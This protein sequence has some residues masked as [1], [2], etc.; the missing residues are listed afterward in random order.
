MV[1]AAISLRVFDLVLWRVLVVSL[2]FSPRVG[3]SVRNVFVH[4]RR[5][6]LQ[7]LQGSIEVRG[8]RAEAGNNSRCRGQKPKASD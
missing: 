4:S 1:S 8:A 6:I 5:N 7:I 3:L 2:Q